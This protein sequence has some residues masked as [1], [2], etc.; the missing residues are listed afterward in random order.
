MRTCIFLSETFWTSERI[1]ERRGAAA[2]AAGEA[3][4]QRSSDRIM[5]PSSDG[6]TGLVTSLLFSPAGARWGAAAAIDR[7]VR[8]AS[9]F[10][11]RQAAQRRTD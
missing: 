10:I 1:T 8:M 4:D 2:L 3:T 6:L 11:F 7:D 5:C 9:V